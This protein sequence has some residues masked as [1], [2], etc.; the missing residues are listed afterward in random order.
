MAEKKISK[1]RDAS[2]YQIIYSKIAAK[3]L[4]PLDTYWTLEKV[5][6]VKWWINQ[7]LSQEDEL[8]SSTFKPTEIVTVALTE[9][10]YTC[11][12]FLICLYFILKK[13]Y[14]VKHDNVIDCPRGGCSWW[15]LWAT[16]QSDSETI[17]P[18][19]SFKSLT[20]HFLNYFTLRMTTC[21]RLCWG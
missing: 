20:L 6:G 18:G 14:L 19:K 12:F 10:I 8:K 9:G 3:P 21:Q 1:V 5:H 2:V 4:R 11:F 16:N 17:F 15:D 7:I 13:S